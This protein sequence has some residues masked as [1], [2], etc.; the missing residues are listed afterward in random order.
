MPNDRLRNNN[1][2]IALAIEMLAK[3]VTSLQLGMVNL[4]CHVGVGVGEAYRRYSLP[5]AQTLP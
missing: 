5:E 3:L 2:N 1:F 4:N